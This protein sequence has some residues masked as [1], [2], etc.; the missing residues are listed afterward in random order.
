MTGPK[1]TRVIAA[2]RGMSLRLPV[3]LLGTRKHLRRTRTLMRFDG[4]H[5]TTYG[6]TPINRQKLPTR[7]W[8]SSRQGA[9]YGRDPGTSRGQHANS[10]T[11]C[12]S[13][14]DGNCDS[15]GYTYSNGYANPITDT[16]TNTD[17]DAHWR[18]DCH[19]QPGNQCGQF[20]SHPQR[21]SQSPGPNHHGSFSVW[22]NDQL[23]VYNCQPNQDWQRD[24]KRRCEHQRFDGEYYLSFSDR[25]HQQQR[26]QVRCGPDFY[27]DRT[28]CCHDQCRNARGASFSHTQRLG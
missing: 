25:G 24:A 21:G 17:G 8:A 23:R 13:D 18:P 12:Q 11:Y 22:N 19:H 15:H 20:F 3:L 27:H 1:I 2:R 14:T 7:Q 9:H 4:A 5:C 28:S 6:S 26:H 10:D 16:N